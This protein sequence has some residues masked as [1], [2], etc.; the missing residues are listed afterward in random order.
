[1]SKPKVVFDC[2]YGSRAICIMG[3]HLAG[4]RHSEPVTICVQKVAAMFS[5]NN[6]LD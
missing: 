4:N 5:E 1:M 6:R 2:P 3:L